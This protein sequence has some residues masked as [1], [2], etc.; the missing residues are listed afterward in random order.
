MTGSFFA[1]MFYI[2]YE[3]ERKAKREGEVLFLE[4]WI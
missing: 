4:D 2:K 3:G 1:G